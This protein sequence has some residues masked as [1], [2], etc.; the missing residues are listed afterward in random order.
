MTKPIYPSHHLAP[1][2]RAKSPPPP[3]SSCQVPWLTSLSKQSYAVPCITSL[4][5]IPSS[6]SFMHN[7]CPPFLSLIRQESAQVNFK[8][9]CA[10]PMVNVSDSAA[11]LNFKLARK[12]ANPGRQ[13]AV[14]T[15]Y[16]TVATNTCGS[17]VRTLFHITLLA[18]T[19]LW[20]LVNF[21][22]NLCTPA[23]EP[24]WKVAQIWVA[25]RDFKFLPRFKWDLQ[26]SGMLRS[27][28]W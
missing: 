11:K 18:P 4:L 26:F 20:W 10:E 21:F 7:Q 14:A 28:N 5:L 27:V 22:K 25:L 15:G 8:P 3:T 12:W 16:C 24:H 19:I 2:S 13:V 17:S 1:V 6:R 23:S 9:G